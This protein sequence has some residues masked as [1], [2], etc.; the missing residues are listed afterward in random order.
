METIETTAIEPK[1][2]GKILKQSNALVQMANDFK[3]DSDIALHQAVELEK[4]MKLYLE[5]Y[6]TYHDKEIELAN[7]LHKHLCSKRN[8]I[9]DGVKLAWKALKDR[10]AAYQAKQEEERLAKIREAEAKAKR[11]EAEKQAKIQAKI[12]EENAKIRAQKREEARIQAEK[13]AEI[14]KIRNKAKAEE[15][16]VAEEARRKEQARIDEEAR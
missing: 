7:A 3:V 6:G 9:V 16:R 10:R 12:D 11:E 13:D 15:M 5:T 4:D 14:A 2:D 8:A 1:E